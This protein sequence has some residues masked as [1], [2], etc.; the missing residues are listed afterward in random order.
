MDLLARARTWRDSVAI[1][2]RKRKGSLSSLTEVRWEVPWKGRGRSD[3]ILQLGSRGQQR[4]QSDWICTA[5]IKIP[6]D[7]SIKNDITL[8]LQFFSCAWRT[9][10]KQTP[11]PFWTLGKNDGDKIINRVSASSHLEVEKGT[12]T[13]KFWKTEMDEDWDT[14]FH[15]AATFQ[16][17]SGRC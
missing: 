12:R 1:M 15:S 17:A 14:Q 2:W 8:H 7:F 10:C 9:P 11:L 5:S 4:A 6:C 3:A 16:Q 13:K